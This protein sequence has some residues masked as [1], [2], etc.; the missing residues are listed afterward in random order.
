MSTPEKD[1]GVIM[2]LLERFEKFRLPAALKLKEKVD[3]G[4]LLDNRDMMFLEKFTADGEKIQP[5]IDK[6]PEYQEL[7]HR[8]TN[9]LREI[10]AKA[11]ENEKN[12]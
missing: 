6:H 1:L 9:L 5:L 10:T 11:L 2:A 8:A 12:Q 3:N 4:G 7:A